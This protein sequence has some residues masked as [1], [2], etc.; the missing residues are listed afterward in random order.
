MSV[1]K[2]QWF[3][4]MLA[5]AQTALY[6]GLIA[7]GY[8][9]DQH[10]LRHFDALAFIK[11]DLERPF[12]ERYEFCGDWIRFSNTQSVLAGLELPVYFLGGLLYEVMTWGQTCP[13][14]LIVPRGQVIL[15]TLVSPV[16]F[17]VGLSIRRLGQHRWRPRAQRPWTRA[18]LI[19]TLLPTLFGIPAVLIGTLGLVIS[20]E[21][22]RLLFA[23]FWML[24]AAALAAERLRIWPFAKLPVTP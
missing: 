6:L 19:F 3:P 15:A 13:E 21:S 20:N 14:M 22:A 10:E 17:L 2:S 12:F 8:W 24:Y 4:A 5:L 9:T 7:Y 23:G 1:I 18:M 11:E 16:W